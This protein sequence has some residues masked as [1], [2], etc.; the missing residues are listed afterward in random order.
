MSRL[1]R[2]S[3]EEWRARALAAKG[4]VEKLA[5]SCGVSRRQLER[6]FREWRG[7]CPVR[8]LNEVRLSHAPRLL[9]QGLTV[10][11]IAGRLGYEDASHFAKAFRGYHGV[12]PSKFTEAAP[13]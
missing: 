1:E 6:Y 3:L 8:W 13:N 5:E 4:S 9:T 10:K 7:V 2:I 12:P 11:E